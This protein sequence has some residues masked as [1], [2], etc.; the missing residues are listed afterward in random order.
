MKPNPDVINPPDGSK[1][2]LDR[3]IREYQSGETTFPELMIYLNA[4]A[5]NVPRKLRAVSY[6]L[7]KVLDSVT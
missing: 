6:C 1:T 4:K 2:P 7:R 5:S 3:W